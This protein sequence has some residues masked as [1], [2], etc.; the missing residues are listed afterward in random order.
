MGG[1]VKNLWLYTTVLI[2]YALIHQQ[3]MADE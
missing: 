3:V 1:R 2:I